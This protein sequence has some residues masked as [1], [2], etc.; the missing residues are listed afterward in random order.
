MSL[1][2]ELQ[3]YGLGLSCRMNILC[4]SLSLACGPGRLSSVESL[5]A[6]SSLCVIGSNE[7]SI[8]VCAE[9]IGSPQNIGTIHKSQLIVAL[10]VFF[11][12]F[13]FLIVCSMC[14]CASYHICDY[15]CTCSLNAKPS[16]T[17]ISAMQVSESFIRSPV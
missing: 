10:H 17:W 8:Q 9:N 3:C 15:L 7:L 4:S 12:F 2:S 13:K 1:N 16:F 14:S 6:L 11:F 5:L